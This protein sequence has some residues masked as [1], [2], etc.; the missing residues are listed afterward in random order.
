[1]SPT[2]TSKVEILEAMVFLL[3]RKLKPTNQNVADLVGCGRSTAQ[4]HLAEIRRKL[5]KKYAHAAGETSGTSGIEKSLGRHKTPAPEFAPDEDEE[6]D[7]NV[8]ITKEEDEELKDV[9]IKHE[10]DNFV[11]LTDD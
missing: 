3:E 8:Q 5:K 7:V 4:N 11:D 2:K 6:D 1:M 9:I 10:A